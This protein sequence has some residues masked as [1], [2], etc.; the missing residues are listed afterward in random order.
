MAN[1]KIPDA[2]TRLYPATRLIFRTIAEAEKGTQLVH[3]V[4]RLGPYF[5]WV[6]FS[7]HSFFRQVAY[8]AL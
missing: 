1:N 7:S 5:H 2:E 4:R 8:Q 6:P 3:Q